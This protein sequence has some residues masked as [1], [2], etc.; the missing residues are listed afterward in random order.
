MSLSENGQGVHFHLRDGVGE[1]GSETRDGTDC[2][3][4]RSCV[5]RRASPKTV[6]EFGRAGR[7]E[8]LER[9][10]LIER[11]EPD[12]H[13]PVELHQDPACPNRNN[14]AEVAIDPRADKE[15]GH[16]PYLLLEQE[17][18][19]AP[20]GLLRPPQHA[21]GRGYDRVDG[22]LSRQRPAQPRFCEL[23]PRPGISVRSGIRSPPPPRRPRRWCSR[24][25]RRG[26]QSR[27]GQGC[28]ELPARSALGR[29]TARACFPRSFA[30]HPRSAAPASARG[31]PPT[32]RSGQAPENLPRSRVDRRR[33]P[34]GRRLPNRGESRQRGST[35]RRAV[36]RPASRP[37]QQRS[38]GASSVQPAEGRA[39][40]CILQEHKTANL[41]MCAEHARAPTGDLRIVEPGPG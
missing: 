7:A 3:R 16:R 23:C 33:R 29:S 38:A 21:A 11:R 39:P 34:P 27:R 41:V 40:R 22:C 24:G 10:R 17:T 2:A 35:Q 26:L 4:R 31:Q 28:R 19:D 20:A 13:V 14:R 25:A 30:P 8:G 15:L 9:S 36:S 1:I 18:K 6:E 5:S 37:P 12:G 32:P